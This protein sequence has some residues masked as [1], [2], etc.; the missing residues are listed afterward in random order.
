MQAKI[1]TKS[2]LLVEGKPDDEVLTLRALKN[3]N[4]AHKVVVARDGVEALD[5]LFASGTYAVR[6]NRDMPELRLPV[7]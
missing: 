4:L 3:H 6:H 7:L 5:Y 2:I 1:E